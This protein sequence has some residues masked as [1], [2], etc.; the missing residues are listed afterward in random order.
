MATTVTPSGGYVRMLLNNGLDS[1]G[2]VKTIAYRLPNTKKTLDF[3]STAIAEKV[4]DVADKLENIMAKTIYSLEAIQT[5]TIED[6]G[7]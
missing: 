6:D 5:F 3:S 1:S 4:S 7:E 2:N